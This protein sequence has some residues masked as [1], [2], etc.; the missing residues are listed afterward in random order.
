MNSVVPIILNFELIFVAQNDSSFQCLCHAASNRLRTRGNISIDEAVIRDQLLQLTTSWRH[1]VDEIPLKFKF[2]TPSS[3][4]CDERSCAV[5][6]R[7]QANPMTI[8]NN[9]SANV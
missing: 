8:A 6:M 9:G 1:C 4:A 2:F 5:K 7:F 3:A